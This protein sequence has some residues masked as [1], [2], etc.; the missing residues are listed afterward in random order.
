MLKVYL[1]IFVSQKVQQ[2]R[3]YKR[4]KVNRVK[5]TQSIRDD[6]RNRC[7]LRRLK[8]CLFEQFSKFLNIAFVTLIRVAT[9]FWTRNSLSFEGFRG[10]N[11]TFFPDH[12]KR[13]LGCKRKL[14]SYTYFPYLL[15]VVRDVKIMLNCAVEKFKIMRPLNAKKRKL[16][17]IMRSK[18]EN[19]AKSL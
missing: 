11:L 4:S 1:R 10:Q 19:Y 9:I 18:N 3:N 14:F 2:L 12:R 17:K 5:L 16:C 15:V 6:G 13:L 8:Q 7:V